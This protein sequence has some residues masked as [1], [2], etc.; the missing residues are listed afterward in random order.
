MKEA[1][2]TVF[3]VKFLVHMLCPCCI[4]FCNSK[5]E[6]HL[7]IQK[8]SGNKVQITIKLAVMFLETHD[9]LFS[10]VFSELPL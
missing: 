6:P 2:P 1:N 8:D 10:K 9:L 7:G 5:S 3:K 4:I